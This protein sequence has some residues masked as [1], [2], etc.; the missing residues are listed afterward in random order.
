MNGI[1]ANSDAVS[2]KLETAPDKFTACSL[3][4]CR[5]YADLI[6]P[7]SIP[8]RIYTWRNAMFLAIPDAPSGADK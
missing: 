4:S 8:S 7:Q 5:P 2:E 6:T 1:N 3:S